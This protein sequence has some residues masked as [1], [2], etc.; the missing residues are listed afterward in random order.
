MVNN[1]R[2]FFR[3]H[4]RKF[5]DGS[6]ALNFTEAEFFRKVLPYEKNATIFDSELTWSFEAY[7]DAFI[8]EGYKDVAC[9]GVDLNTPDKSFGYIVGIDGQAFSMVAK[10][11][12][13]NWL[14]IFNG[15]L[16]FE[17]LDNGR[18]FLEGVQ[19]FRDMGARGGTLSSIA[20]QLFKAHFGSKYAMYYPDCRKTEIKEGVTVYDYIREGYR[21]GWNYL[22]PEHSGHKI[23]NGYI[24]DKNSLYPWLLA[25]AVLPYGYG[26]YREG[27]PSNELLK[28]AKEGKFFVFIKIKT[29]FHVKHNFLPFVTLEPNEEPNTQGE[30]ELLLTLQEYNLFLKHY[31]TEYIEY[32]D[33]VYFNAMRGIARDFVREFYTKK[34]QST[35]IKRKTYKGVMNYVIG[36]LSKKIERHNLVKVDGNWKVV[37][38]ELKEPSA[39]YVGAAITSLGRVCIVRDA[40]SHFDSFIYSDTD[41]LHLTEPA[42]DITVGDCIGQYKLEHTYEEAAYIKRKWYGYKDGEGSVH[43]VTA[44]IPAGEARRI[45]EEQRGQDIEEIMRH[46]TILI[47]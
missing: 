23:E 43:L 10:V 32:V 22:K 31:D 26:K 25:G 18:E 35:G 34:S 8:S 6:H 1:K 41:S 30:G 44:G 33:H 39:L 38:T 28:M 16:L 14:H 21:A 20:M 29:M 3:G 27:K 13:Y 2:N 36:S 12:P 17:D 4:N 46:L 9:Q 45:E 40:Q 42:S 24:Y 47:E 5:Y 7:Y 37:E 11:G 19:I 15:D